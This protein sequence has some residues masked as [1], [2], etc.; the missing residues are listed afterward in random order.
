MKIRWRPNATVAAVVV[1]DGRYL[2]VRELPE[3]AERAV[4]NQ[5]AGHLEQGETLME[6]VRREVLEETRWEVEVSGYLGVAML[7]ASNDTTYLR[8]TFLCSPV[9][10]HSDRHLDNGI[11][12]AHWMGFDEIERLEPIHRSHLVLEVLRQHRAGLCAPL[13]L[14]IES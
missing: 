4:L 7:T 14:I 8:H 5:P 6:A 11:I 1:K 13:S 12:S 2:M 9:L 10:E 3:G